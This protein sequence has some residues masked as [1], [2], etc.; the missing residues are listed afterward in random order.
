MDPKVIQSQ[1]V[2]RMLK[3]YPQLGDTHFEFAWGGSIGVPVNRV[4]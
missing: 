3:I 1:L 4:P 2:P